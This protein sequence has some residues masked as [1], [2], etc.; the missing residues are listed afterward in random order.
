M[1]GPQISLLH[2][3][4]F[5]LLDFG[6]A[7]S[8]YA[9]CRSGIPKAVDRGLVFNGDLF[10]ALDPDLVD[11][12]DT[13]LQRLGLISIALGFR[14]FGLSVLRDA[15]LL[16]SAELADIEDALSKVRMRRK[17]RQAWERFPASVA[18]TLYT[19]KRYLRAIRGKK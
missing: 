17:I 2:D 7:M 16:S 4:G 14:S 6:A 19:P 15:K 11:M 5:R 9:R 10:F 8:Q 13:D 1:P 3:H 18:R 12:S